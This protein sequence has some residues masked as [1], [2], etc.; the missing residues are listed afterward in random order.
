MHT[1]SRAGN[2]YIRAFSD[3]SICKARKPSNWNCNRATI[4]KIDC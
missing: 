4:F 1:K 2:L 3:C